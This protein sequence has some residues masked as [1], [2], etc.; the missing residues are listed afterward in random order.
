[1]PHSNWLRPTWRLPIWDFYSVSEYTKYAICKT[2]EDL[3]SQG[4]ETTKLYNTPNLVAHLKAIHA[5][6]YAM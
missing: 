4:G 1:M 2:Y 6:E 5:N 3:V